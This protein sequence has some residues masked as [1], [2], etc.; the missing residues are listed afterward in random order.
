MWFWPIGCDNSGNGEV[1]EEGK[2]LSQSYCVACHQVPEPDLL[3][4][5]VWEGHVLPLMGAMLG[6]YPADTGRYSRSELLGLG[7]EREARLAA[8]TF[9]AQAVLS[10]EAW[11][12][13]QAY[14][15]Q[16]APVTL[17]DTPALKLSSNLELF[18]AQRPSH[19]LSPPSTTLLQFGSRGG[20]YLG[21]A[22]TQRLY[23]LNS[24]GEVQGAANVRE[25]AVDLIET[26]QALFLT[27][28]G[29]FSP[30]EVPSGFFMQLPTAGNAPPRC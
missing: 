13:I 2:V 28:M 8:N 12:A 23:V 11:E 26:P 10:N 17:P 24:S 30:T 18:H 6:Q 9:P 22:N 15:L 14:Y 29:S 20:L 16:E 19:R 1:A 4:R 25:G 27:V 3:P 5:S 7:A 21:D